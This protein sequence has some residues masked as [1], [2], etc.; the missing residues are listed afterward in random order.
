MVTCAADCGNAFLHCINN[1]KY[2]II[3]GPK[4]GELEGHILLTLGCLCSLQMSSARWHKFLSETLRKMGLV[5][6]KADPDIRIKDCSTPYAYCCVYVD[7]VIL[8]ATFG[9]YEI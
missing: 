2:Y 7:D 6:S 5:P 8:I 3:A 9:Y 4:F 1:E